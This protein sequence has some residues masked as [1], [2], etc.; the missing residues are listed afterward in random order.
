MKKLIATILALG[1]LLIS[2]ATGFAGKEDIVCPCGCKQVAV[3]CGCPVAKK[4]LRGA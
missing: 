3:T 1:V 2:G 4:V